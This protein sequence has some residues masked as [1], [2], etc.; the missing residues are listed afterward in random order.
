MVGGI[1]SKEASGYTALDRPGQVKMAVTFDKEGASIE[2]VIC[3]CD[4]VEDVVVPVEYLDHL[5]KKERDPD[6]IPLL[7]PMM[8]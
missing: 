7:S 5:L 3:F 6:W 2:G 4:L 1:D 8:S